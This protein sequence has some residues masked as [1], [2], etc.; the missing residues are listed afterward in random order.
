MDIRLDDQPGT[1]EGRP[2]AAGL[3]IGVYCLTSDVTDGLRHPKPRSV[4]L[5]VF[6][7]IELIEVDGAI[8]PRRRHRPLSSRA[9]QKCPVGT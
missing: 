7:E 8:D 5:P 3:R 6:G 4:R 1:R 9:V 2:G